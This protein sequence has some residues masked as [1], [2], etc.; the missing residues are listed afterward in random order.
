MS[1][2]P[3]GV[4]NYTYAQDMAVLRTKTH[5]VMFFGFLILLFAA[6][7]Y[8]DNYWLGIANLIGITLVAA[9]GLNI[10]IGY[11]GQLSIGHAGFMA[12]GAYVS[13]LMAAHWTPSIAAI[14]A[15]V[16]LANALVGFVLGAICLRMVGPYLALA[17]I[18]FVEIVRVVSLNLAVTGGATGILVSSCL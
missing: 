18:A 5:W 13:G 4:R 6:P 12:I 16:I 9:T 1:S 8:L 10:L 17:T 7:L 14:W 11:C 15:V 2:L 3:T